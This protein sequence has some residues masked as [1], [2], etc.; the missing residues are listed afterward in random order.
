ML[1]VR[2]NVVR[3]AQMISTYSWLRNDRNIWVRAQHTGSTASL[4]EKPG[5]VVI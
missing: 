2:A 1:S 5:Y 3:Y 4:T